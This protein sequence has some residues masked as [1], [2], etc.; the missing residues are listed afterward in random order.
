MEVIHDNSHDSLTL[1]GVNH[2]TLLAIQS[3]FKFV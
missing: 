1:T 3:D 2:A